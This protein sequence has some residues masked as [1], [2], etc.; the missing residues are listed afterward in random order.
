[1]RRVFG[2]SLLVV[3]VCLAAR[4]LA[5]DAESAATD[6]STVEEDAGTTIVVTGTRVTRSE[7]DFANPVVSPVGRSHPGLGAHQPGR[8][9]GPEPCAGRLGDRGADRRIA[10]RV[11]R[12][13]ARPAQ[14]AQPRH[15]PHAGA[16]RRP[17]SRR[18]G[19]RIGGGRHQCHPDRPDRG[20][21]RAHRRRFGDLRRRRRVGRGQL[22]PQAR[23]RGRHRARAVRHLEVWRRREPV[24]RGHAGAE[25]RRRAR[26]LRDRLRIR[27]GC[28]GLGPGPAL[29]AQSGCRRAVPQPGRH[30]RPPARSRP[31]LLRRRPLRRQRADGGGRRRLRFR[32]RL[33]RQRAGVRPRPGARRDRA[34]TPR[35]GRAHRSTGTRATCSPGSSVTCSTRSAITRSAMR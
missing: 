17:A 7:L 31:D 27:Q 6:E 23:F 29:L 25:F 4:V 22:P 14:L 19:R 21:R 24:R 12:S 5:Q 9:A 33:R 18:G 1:M 20:G 34:V 2:C 11:R 30:S 3:G 35:A 15:R 13:R 32:R 28:A 8:P 16:G 26:Q 10:V